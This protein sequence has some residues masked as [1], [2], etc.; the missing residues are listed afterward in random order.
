MWNSPKINKRYVNIKRESKR[1][2]KK[3]QFPASHQP[4]YPGT[5]TRPPAQLLPGLPLGMSLS[6]Q[7]YQQNPWPKGG[8]NL[9]QW[10]LSK[11]VHSAMPKEQTTEPPLHLCVQDLWLHLTDQRAL[12]AWLLGCSR[13]AHAWLLVRI[14]HPLPRLDSAQVTSRK[15]CIFQWKVNAPRVLRN[16]ESDCL[17]VIAETAPEQYL[18]L[19]REDLS[20]Y[21]PS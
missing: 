17:P 9:V 18:S 16:Q 2:T 7:L 4:E 15:E 8:R 14:T 1:K 3:E 13:S 11:H 12:W 21:T 10:V 20:C 19:L 5:S 6:W